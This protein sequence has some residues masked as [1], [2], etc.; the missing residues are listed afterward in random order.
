MQITFAV[1]TRNKPI[2]I[3]SGMK[4]GSDVV[5]ETKTFK[6][7]V[8]EQDDDNSTLKS[9][10]QIVSSQKLEEVGMVAFPQLPPEMESE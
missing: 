2:L 9:W 10:L 8:F 1:K 3:G 7:V 6:S 4:I 5:A